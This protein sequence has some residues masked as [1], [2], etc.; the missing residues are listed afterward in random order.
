MTWLK[1]LISSTNMRPM[2]YKR[3]SEHRFLVMF[4]ITLICLGLTI[5][6]SWIGIIH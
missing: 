5:A 2:A 3:P 4:A 6:L 1:I